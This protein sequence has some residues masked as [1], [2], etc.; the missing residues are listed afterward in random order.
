MAAKKAQK[1][2]IAILTGGGDVPGLNPC[3]KA[4]VYRASREGVRVLG[5]RRGWAGLLEYDPDNKAALKSCFGGAGIPPIHH[6]IQEL[7]PNDVRTIDRSGGTYLHTSRTNP[8]ATR[9][10]E[11]P[12]F[13][14]RK[15]RKKETV[16]DFTPQV[17][18]NLA[19]LG[20]DAI[21]PIGGDDTLS[22]AERLHKEGF[23]VIAIPKTMDNDVFGTDYCIGFSTAITRSV[24]FIHALRTSTGSHERIAVIELFGRYCGETSLISAYL[25]GVDRAV[26]SEVPFDPEKL[27]KLV[28]EDKRANPKNYAMITI[29]EGAKM[30]GGNMQ[31]SGQADAYGHLKL[32]GIGEQ[33]GAILKQL[34]GEHIL[35]QRLSY[36]MRSGVPDSLD[37]MVAVNFAHMAIDLFMKGAFGRLV[38]LNRGIYTDIPLST[39]ASGQKRVDI[40]EL[41]DVDAYRPK[42]RHVGG[43][44]MFLY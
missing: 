14:K 17:L 30:I 25:A 12:A 15:Y 9:L 10:Q 27:A 40:H 19:H 44:P 36:L 31:A 4:L 26:I 43:K 3:I 18:T 8:S 28:L 32:G 2:T 7:L 5:V 29:S 24:G 20:V 16:R 1:Q 22:F 13:L 37:L 23:P 34:T 11:A 33:T 41:Y 35:N 39:I 6:C 42:V 21:I 38:A